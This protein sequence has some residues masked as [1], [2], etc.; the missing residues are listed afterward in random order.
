MKEVLQYLLNSS[1]PLIKESELEEMINM[2]Q[3]E[4]QTYADEIKVIHSNTSLIIII[5][6][7]AILRLTEILIDSSVTCYMIIM[8]VEVILK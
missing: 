7:R 5:V 8:F 4:W 2:T 1:V 6:I 3:Y